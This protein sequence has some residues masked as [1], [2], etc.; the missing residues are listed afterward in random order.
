MNKQPRITMTMIQ[1]SLSCKHSGTGSWLVR[2]DIGMYLH[3]KQPRLERVLH[4][5]GCG[6]SYP[7]HTVRD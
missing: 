2:Y 3:N 5:T 7:Y 1:H 4:C 6:K